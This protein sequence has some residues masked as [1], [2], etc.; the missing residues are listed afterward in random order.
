MHTRWTAKELQEKADNEILLQLVIERR[1]ELKLNSPL[2]ARLQ[3]VQQKLGKKSMKGKPKQK[4]NASFD[5][6][7][8]LNHSYPN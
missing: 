6:W 2:D 1:E 7:G 8:W 3:K 4:S 5:R